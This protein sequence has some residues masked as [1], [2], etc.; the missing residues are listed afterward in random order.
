MIYLLANTLGGALLFSLTAL[1][2]S[3]PAV[4]DKA[5]FCYWGAGHAL[6]E[7]SVGMIINRMHKEMQEK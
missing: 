1:S 7:L 6:Y 5:A 4:I 3:T 2:A